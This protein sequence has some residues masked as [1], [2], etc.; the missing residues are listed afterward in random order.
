M[1]PA[2]TLSTRM[3]LRSILA[4]SSADAGAVAPPQTASAGLSAVQFGALIAQFFPKAAA[5]RLFGLSESVER[6]ARRS[7]PA[8]T[9]RTLHHFARTVRNA[10]CR[11]DRKARA[12][13]QSPLAGSRPRHRGELN[14]LMTR[15]FKPLALR[16]K[17]DM[18]WKKFFYRLIC[19]DA[20]YSLCT[21][22]SCAECD[23]FA[24]CFGEETGDVPPGAYPPRV[25][26]A[27]H[28]GS[29]VTSVCL[30]TLRHRNVDCIRRTQSE[31]RARKN[32]SATFISEE[33]DSILSARGLQH[34][35]G[36]R[37][38][39]SELPHA[40]PFCQGGNKLK[41]RDNSSVYSNYEASDGHSFRDNCSRHDSLT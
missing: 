39:H 7:L 40:N 18:K 14:E 19:A 12:A 1:L 31:I 34:R 23:D 13:A 41:W 10:A 28:S 26:G 29:N 32:A 35:R 11:H 36:E 2:A 6:D 33:A 21:A 4:V 27:E 16:N 30:S 9:A 37:A 8:R 15:H 22:P 17:G 3:L 5:W 25:R 20:S 38:A 24:Q